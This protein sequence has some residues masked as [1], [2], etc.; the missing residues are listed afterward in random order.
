M[1]IE[2]LAKKCA[3][4]QVIYPYAE[5]S[6]GISVRVHDRHNEIARLITAPTLDEAVED[7]LT[8][9]RHVPKPKTPRTTDR[10]STGRTGATQTKP[11]L[12]LKQPDPPKKLKLKIKGKK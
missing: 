4:V 6:W 8:Y 9:A 1:T 3:W 11:K 5:D 2:A 12:K 7:A 10:P